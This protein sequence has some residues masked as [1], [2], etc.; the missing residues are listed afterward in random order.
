MTTDQQ[1]VVGDPFVCV[2]DN[3]LGS[4][5]PGRLHLAGQQET[6]VGHG[7]HVVARHELHR[8]HPIEVGHGQRQHHQVAVL[9]I[10]DLN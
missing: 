5:W 2:V 9:S 8:E 3:L 10:A 6:G 7:Q 1:F 4:E